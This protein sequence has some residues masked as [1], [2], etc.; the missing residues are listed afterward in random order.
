MSSIVGKPG[1]TINVH[2]LFLQD[3]VVFKLSAFLKSFVAWSLQLF[4]YRTSS[5]PSGTLAVIDHRTGNHYELEI[6]N[7]AVH[8]VDLQAVNAGTGHDMAD[9]MK[10]GLRVLDPGFQNTAVM[11]SGITFV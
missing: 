6:S 2:M 10:S 1:H 11:K 7:N 9:R 3:Y 8:A 4:H 5:S